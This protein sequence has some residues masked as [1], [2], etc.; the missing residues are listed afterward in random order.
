MLTLAAEAPDVSSPDAQHISPRLA[1]TSWRRQAM[2]FGLIGIVLTGAYFLLYLLLRRELDAQPAN[3]LAWTVTAIIDTA[4]N[5]RFTFE[6]TQR[7]SAGRAQAEG[8]AVFGLGL[9]LTS[10]AL[11]GLDALVPAPGPVLELLALG[12]ANLA[13]GLLR[14]ELLRRWV[15]AEGRRRPASLGVRPVLGDSRI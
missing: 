3:Y 8:L 15:F 5:R 14:F 13:A 7:V 11:A 4:A 12:G 10:A 6:A 1:D 9:V 2:W